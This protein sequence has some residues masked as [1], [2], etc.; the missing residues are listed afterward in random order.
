M[1]GQEDLIPIGS[2]QIW[3]DNLYLRAVSQN[4]PPGPTRKNL[5]ITLIAVAPNEGPGTALGYLTSMTLQG[6]DLGPTV[7]VFGDEKVYIEGALSNRIHLRAGM[8]NLNEFSG[9]CPEN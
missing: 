9:L 1:L 3:L 7:G 4:V 8:G 5:F 6:D 2:E